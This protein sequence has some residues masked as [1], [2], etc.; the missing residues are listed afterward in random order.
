MEVRDELAKQGPLAQRT[1]G[2]RNT[3]RICHPLSMALPAFAKRLLCMPFDQLDGDSNMPRVA[4]PDFGAS[5]RMVVSPGREADGIIHM[6]GGQS[7]HPLSPFWGAGHADWVHGRATRF[8]PGEARYSLRI[9]PAGPH[10]RTRGKH[11]RQDR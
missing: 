1:W 10:L 3:A 6:P 7:G 5:E 4:A 11:A 8:L 2:E 9:V